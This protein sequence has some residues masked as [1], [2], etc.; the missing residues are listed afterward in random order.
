MD[1]PATKV[2]KIHKPEAVDGNAAS[3]SDSEMASVEQASIAGS[4]D[5]RQSMESP[6]GDGETVQ[7]ERVGKGYMYKRCP[8]CSTVQG[9]SYAKCPKCYYAFTS[10]GC[11]YTVIYVSH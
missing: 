5:P 4:D 1:S 2:S 10:K 6:A 9:S 7:L 3:G 8:K 11:N